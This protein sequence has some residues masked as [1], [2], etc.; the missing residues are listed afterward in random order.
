[1]LRLAPICEN[2]TKQTLRVVTHSK[3]ASRLQLGLDPGAHFKT[4]AHMP[5]LELM[6][7][8]LGASAASRRRVSSIVGDFPRIPPHLVGEHCILCLK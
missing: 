6:T 5:R 8:D 2:S 3:T 7:F 1:M 4:P